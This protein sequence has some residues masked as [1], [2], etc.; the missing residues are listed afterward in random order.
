M[1]PAHRRAEC[2]D[3]L[4]R[5]GEGALVDGEGDPAPLAASPSTPALVIV[6]LGSPLGV[7]AG[8]S[9]LAAGGG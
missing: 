6:A 7:V 3:R 4:L 1:R 2:V 9:V 5:R 8:T